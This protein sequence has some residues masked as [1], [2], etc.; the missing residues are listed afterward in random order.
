MRTADRAP[1]LRCQLLLVVTVL[2]SLGANRPNVVLVMTDDQGYGDLSCHGNPLLK[3]PAIDSLAAD[4]V[5]LTDYHVSP[6]CSPTR[7]ALLTGHWTNRTGVWH[8]IMGRSLLRE[9][10]VTLGTLFQRAGYATGMFGKW[11]LGDNYPVR[12]TDCGFDFSVNHKAGGVGELSDYWG[13]TYFDDVYYVNNEPRQFEGY[14]TD[15]WFEEAMKFI[16]ENRDKPFFVYL[17]TNAPHGPLYVDLK[18]A[19]PYKHLVGKEIVSAEFYGMIVNLDENFGKLE[20]YL[21]RTGLADNTILIFMTDNGSAN[22]VSADGKLGYNQ[23]LRGKKGSRTEGGHRVPFFIR[24]NDGKVS[25]GWDIHEVAAHVDL[26]PTLAGLCNLK[27]PRHKQLD[28][29]DFSPL[30]L[31]NKKKLEERTVFVHSRQDWRPPMDVN[32][33]CIIRGKWRLVNVRELYD[34]EADRRQK[35]NLASQ[36]PEIV[37]SLLADNAAFLKKSKSNPEY[38]E[39]PVSVIG[40]EKQKEVKLT[41]QHAI[42]EDRGYWKCE[43]VSAG[44]TSLNDKHA[45]RVEREGRYRIA[46]M[47]WP[48]ECPGPI[49]GIP[50]ENPKDWFDYKTIAPEK[51]RIEI[52]NQIIEKPINPDDYEVVFEVSLEPG[53]TMLT[54]DFIEGESM[55]GVYYTYIEYLGNR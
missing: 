5:R 52:A 46:C 49:L 47:R 53:K 54:N 12:P 9:N 23:G 6:T 16:E 40:D 15:I 34:I 32:E 10:E 13:N 2:F 36:H 38:H 7:S 8:T 31:K 4:A 33:T 41:V 29:V 24:W 44:L 37:K 25:G 51:V 1:L 55:Y 20:A 48:R 19:A 27:I 14:C 35:R 22:G 18:Y 30:L 3:T 39:F 26:I 17:P 45:L 42:G 43:Q 21:Q 11:H 50:A 28:G